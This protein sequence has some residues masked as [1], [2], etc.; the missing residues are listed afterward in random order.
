MVFDT[1]LKYLEGNS[2]VGLMVL[3]FLSFYFMI[4]FGVFLYRYF[5]LSAW[6]SREKKSLRSLFKDSTLDESS[7]LNRCK[8][9]KDYL[10]KEVLEACK[11]AAVREATIGLTILSIIASTAPFI[12]LFG[13]VIGILEA[14]AEFANETRVSLNIIAPVISEALVATA[15]GIFVA[16]PAYSFQLTLKRKSYELFTYLQNQVDIIVSQQ[17]E[18]KQDNVWLGWETWT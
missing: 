17:Q 7:V 16:I 13:T 10:S 18:V 9:G 6:I 1:I 4:V 2:V 14:F 11:S 15:A 5:Y 8:S 12:G 3:I